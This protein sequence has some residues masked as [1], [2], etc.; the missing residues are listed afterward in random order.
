[1]GLF[2]L[3]VDNIETQRAAY[4]TYLINNYSCEKIRLLCE[5]KNYYPSDMLLT[6]IES[7]HRGSVNALFKLSTS[8]SNNQLL[9]LAVQQRNK[10]QSGYAI[11]VFFLNTNRI[12]SNQ[13]IIDWANEWSNHG[14]ISFEI[15][16]NIAD[17]DLRFEFSTDNSCWSWIGTD[18]RYVN[19]NNATIHITIFN[20]VRTDRANVLHEFGHA[21]GFIHEHQ[22]PAAG[23]LWNIPDIYSEFYRRCGWNRQ[24]VQQNVIRRYSTSEISNSTYDDQSIMLYPIEDWMTMH[25][26]YTKE[27]NYDL[28][29]MDRNFIAQVYP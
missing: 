23:I 28:S 18:A 20:D 6:E 12:Y 14:N 2:C 5:R 8:R 16:A 27:Q 10:W 17:A 3:P 7:A 24:M 9:E 1:M 19:P 22:S 13:N 29:A 4:V 25:G 15:V 21:L 26:Y 11:K